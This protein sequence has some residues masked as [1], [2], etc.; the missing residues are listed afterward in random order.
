M[1]NRLAPRLPAEAGLIVL[2]AVVAA[3]VELPVGAIVAAVFAAWIAVALVEIALA[4]GR[5]PRG[6]DGG[7][8][9]ERERAHR[10]GADEAASARA[11][12]GAEH[13]VGAPR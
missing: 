11:V 12:S 10:A 1:L 7:R 4:R 3:L 6:S 13:E 2:V 8:D 5:R 9:G